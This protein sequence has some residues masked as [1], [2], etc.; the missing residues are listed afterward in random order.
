M[1]YSKAGLGQ[2]SNAAILGAD[3]G[4]SRFA[5]PVREGASSRGCEFAETQSRSCGDLALVDR[6][7]SGRLPRGI[8]VSAIPRDSG[9]GA[10][11]GAVRARDG[12]Y[13]DGACNEKGIQFAHASRHGGDRVAYTGISIDCR[14]DFLCVRRVYFARV[15][16]GS[17][18]EHPIFSG[19]V[20]P[21]LLYWKANGG[22]RSGEYR[23]VVVGPFP[24][25]DRDS[26]SMDLGHITFGFARCHN[27][28]GDVRSD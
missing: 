7:R 26:I 20:R 2:S 17:C 28:M 3:K 23:G 19:D 6:G 14:W 27:S 4:R 8:R 25:R 12:Q 9:A 13:R 5:C 11:I 10:R 16:R 22:N 15:L 24:E 18:A 21:D 1:G